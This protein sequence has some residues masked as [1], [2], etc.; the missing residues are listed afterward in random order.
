MMPFVIA[1]ESGQS[2][3]QAS[4]VVTG[5]SAFADDDEGHE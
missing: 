1:R 5:S 4:D 2:S 3:K